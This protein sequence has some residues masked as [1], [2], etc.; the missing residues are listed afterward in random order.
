MDSSP[1]AAAA[2]KQIAAAVAKG[3]VRCEITMHAFDRGGHFGDGPQHVAAQG[4][5][6]DLRAD[7]I[8]L[9]RCDQFLDQFRPRLV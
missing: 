6:D 8:G 9:P 2:F 4:V 1:L 7:A 3:L 5:G